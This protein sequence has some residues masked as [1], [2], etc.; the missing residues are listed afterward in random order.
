MK[1]LANPDI[2]SFIKAEE[3]KHQDAIA[4]APEL[5][6]CRHRE[7]R[8]LITRASKEPNQLKI[9]IIYN[10][11]NDRK[12]FME[13]NFHFFGLAHVNDNNVDLVLCLL[14]LSTVFL[15]DAYN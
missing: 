2:S 15:H 3:A 1:F 4:P 14:L 6:N 5:V 10:S 13:S 12:S 8:P 7:E 11:K 9:I